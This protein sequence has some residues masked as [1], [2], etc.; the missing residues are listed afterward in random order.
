MRLFDR[1][2]VLCSSQQNS[3]VVH[4]I[5]DKSREDLVRANLLLVTSI[6]IATLS[7]PLSAK[8]RPFEDPRAALNPAI[9]A[10][11]AFQAEP[12]DPACHT[13]VMTSTGGAFPKNPHTLAVR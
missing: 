1:H 9:D 10:D 5:N 2:I 6:A 8:A 7:A 12:R 11:A 4:S 13:A 3:A